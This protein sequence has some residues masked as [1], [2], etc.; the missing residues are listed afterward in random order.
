MGLLIGNGCTAGE[1]CSTPLYY[2]RYT[3]EFLFSRGF[4]D[5]NVNNDYKSKC[6]AEW[7]SENT[8]SCRAVQTNIY[9][10]FIGTG[11]SI[12]NIYGKCYVNP[13]MDWIPEVQRKIH[14]YHES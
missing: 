7:N 1:E 8:T 4:L 5:E 14:L 12:Y 2:S 3:T 6:L 9:N 13:K 11:A 10:L